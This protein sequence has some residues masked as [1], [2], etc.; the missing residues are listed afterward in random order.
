MAQNPFTGGNAMERDVLTADRLVP[1]R[2]GEII[3]L[4]N[5]GPLRRR[6]TE[7]GLIP[8]A[9]LRRRYTAPGGSPIAFEVSG[10]LLALRTKDAAQIALREVNEPWT[11]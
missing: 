5:T 6:L 1:G 9:V 4:F 2:A 8:G 3:E 7:L 11:A 10:T